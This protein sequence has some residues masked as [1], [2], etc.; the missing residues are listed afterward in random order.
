MLAVKKTDHA[1]RLERAAHGRR[2]HRHDA[3]VEHHE[4]HPPIALERMG[5][6][7]A[8]DRSRSSRECRS[9]IPM[10]VRAS[11]GRLPNGVIGGVSVAARERG[12]IIDDGSRE[13]LMCAADRFL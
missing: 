4:G 1:S 6:V 5:R 8:A 3:G 12:I 9:R 11:S 10:K 13:E 7:L 2:S